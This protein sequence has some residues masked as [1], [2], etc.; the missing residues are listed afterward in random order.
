VSWT[1]LTGLT[2]QR[3]LYGELT[4]FAAGT[5]GTVKALFR[6]MEMSKTS[7]ANSEVLHYGGP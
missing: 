2:G 7:A 6:R 3:R 1:G 4:F 5:G